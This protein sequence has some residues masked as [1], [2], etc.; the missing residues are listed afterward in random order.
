MPA[1]SNSNVEK[2]ISGRVGGKILRWQTV[3]RAGLSTSACERGDWAMDI[4]RFFGGGAPSKKKKTPSKPTQSPSSSKSSKK[5]SKQGSKQGKKAASKRSKAIKS[6]RKPP[7]VDDDAEDADDFQESAANSGRQKL[8]RRKGRR[9]KAAAASTES[10]PEDVTPTIPKRKRMKRKIIVSDSEEESS[11][12]DAPAPSNPPKAA[13][14]SP[15]RKSPARKSP[16]RKSPAKKKA[17]K[18]TPKKEYKLI[19]PGSF[20]GSSSV[21]KE[22]SAGSASAMVEDEEMQLAKALSL[23]QSEAD[24]GP[25]APRTD[26]T[27]PSRVWQ[28][29]SNLSARSDTGWTTY[30]GADQAKLREAYKSGVSTVSLSNGYTVDL[31]SSIQF[32]TTD[33]SRRRPVRRV[34]ASEAKEG[35]ADSVKKSNEKPSPKP[36]AEVKNQKVAKKETQPVKTEQTP[37]PQPKKRK[38]KPGVER[39]RPPNAGKKPKPDG[40]PGCLDGLTFVITGTLD[41]LEREEAEDLI[42]SLGG[43]VTKAVSGRTSFLLRGFD[44]GE[45]KIEKANEKGVKQVDED[46]LFSLIEKKSAA[47]RS[48]AK[49]ESAATPNSATKP[50]ARSKA[51]PKTSSFS[52]SAGSSSAGSSKREAGSGPPASSMSLWVDKHKPVNAKHLIGNNSNIRKLREFLVRWK[53][54]Q[55]T[56]GGIGRLSKRAILLAGAAGLGKSTA[57]DVLC[58]ELGFSKIEYNASDVRNKKGIEHRVRS[59]TR[60]RGIGEFMFGRGSRKGVR[61]GGTCLVMDEVDGMSGNAD[62]GGMQLLIKIIKETCVPI[63]CI[64]NDDRSQKLRSLKNYC[65][66]LKFRRPSAAQIAPR[67]MAILQSEGMNVER[68]ALEAVVEATRGDI[69]QIL[70]LMQMWR[71]KKES[72]N[73]MDAKRKMGMQNRKD[74]DLGPFDVISKVFSSDFF[75]GPSAQGWAIRKADCFFVDYSLM[76]LM[77]QENYLN[78]HRRAG[79]PLDA[80][81]R[82]DTSPMFARQLQN[83]AALD[84]AATSFSD[85]DLVKTQLMRTQDWGL[86]QHH[87]AMSAVIPGALFAGNLGRPQFPQWLGKFSARNKRQRFYNV[88]KTNLGVESFTSSRDLAMYQITGLR[89]ELLQPMIADHE[90][91]PEAVI[92]LLGRYSLDRDDWEMIMELGDRFGQKLSLKKVPSKVKAAFTRAYKKAGHR[93]KVARKDLKAVKKQARKAAKEQLGDDEPSDDEPVVQAKKKRKAGSKKRKKKQSASGSSS[94]KKRARK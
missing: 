77:I 52:H 58:R 19:D 69:R 47:K 34:S 15:A 73:Y 49:K 45:R 46:F 65:E 66:V 12:S 25:S 11:D 80:P 23:S 35:E 54:A 20:F 41:S 89:R 18:A 87:G 91:G 42:K 76:P 33:P 28:W 92:D 2:K 64:C 4:R 14:K 16:A 6:A 3:A 13:K 60:N 51:L 90:D 24:S 31:D 39:A 9:A 61:T 68:N 44:A 75:G 63:I 86:L 50:K 27:G 36:K 84:A 43:R 48:S 21:K 29:K 82:T 56:S 53:A 40:E 8:K 38:W 88:L 17:K 83:L 7:P 32:S 30:A 71:K 93:L 22:T 74:F 5:G 85:A 59:I 1:R 10:S 57:A 79:N 72:V 26:T 78:V 94:T 62:R 55:T 37:T 67:M 81:P 70:N